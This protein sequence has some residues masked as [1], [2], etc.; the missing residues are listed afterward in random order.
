MKAKLTAFL[1]KLA[2][3]LGRKYVK[4]SLI[5]GI[6]VVIASVIV[7]RPN[8]TQHI[9]QTASKSKT[10]QTK[11]VT[12][13]VEGDQTTVPV[14]NTE[15]APASD[16]KSN[17]TQKSSTPKPTTPATTNKPTAGSTSTT[18]NKP[19]K[20]VVNPTPTPIVNDGTPEIT[21]V[22]VSLNGGAACGANIGY[23]YV[24]NFKDNKPKA[25]TINAKW[26]A[27]GASYGDLPAYSPVS[28]FSQGTLQISDDVA[29]YHGFV[30]HM[31]SYSVRLHIT[32]P[33]NTYSNVLTVP[34]CV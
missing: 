23:H 17:S 9:S 14:Q 33:N 22:S 4:L 25:G 1:K 7:L 26:E 12:A 24:L 2:P 32:S 15:A 5:V 30:S 3:I 21:S 13:K 28:S 19:T 16:T 8:D 27:V 31:S 6:V 10:S 18:T 20:P 29:T 34:A 11:K